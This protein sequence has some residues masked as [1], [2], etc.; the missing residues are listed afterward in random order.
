MCN[1]SNLEEWLDECEWDESN[2]FEALVAVIQAISTI[3]KGRKKRVV[4][5]EDSRG[6]DGTRTYEKSIL[7]NRVMTER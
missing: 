1:E 3:R 7:K 5:K 2:C 4:E 6:V